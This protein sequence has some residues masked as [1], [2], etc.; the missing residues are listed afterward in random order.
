MACEALCEFFPSLFA[1]FIRYMQPTGCDTALYGLSGMKS[2]D[3]CG[4]LWRK[5]YLFT[6]VE[7]GRDIGFKMST[8]GNGQDTRPRGRWGKGRSSL[9]SS[10]LLRT[11]Y[12]SLVPT[13]MPVMNFLSQR[14]SNNIFPLQNMTLIRMTPLN[15][16]RS[17]SKIDPDQ[18]QMRRRELACFLVFWH[19]T[20]A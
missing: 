2:F 6:M 13:L 1:P 4:L 10:G 12:L 20:P 8:D 11:K 5:E 16:H 15:M 19:Q 17:E 9:S 18:L 3:R 14:Y 7:F